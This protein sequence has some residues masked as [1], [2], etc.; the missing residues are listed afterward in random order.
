LAQ[1]TI[2]N[3]DRVNS[4]QNSFIENQNKII[5]EITSQTIM[6]DSLENKEELE[7]IY[8]GLKVGESEFLKKQLGIHLNPAT[9][10]KTIGKKF[11]GKD[12]ENKSTLG[13]NEED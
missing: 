2:E 6:M 11:V 9:V 8:E 5:E 10:L 4:Q 7:E 12:D 13:L 1:Q 3:Q